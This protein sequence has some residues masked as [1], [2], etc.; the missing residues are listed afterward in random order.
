MTNELGQQIGAFLSAHHV[1]SL[2]TLGPSGPHA[3]NLLYACDGLALLWVSDADS[4]HSREIEADPRVEATVAPDYSDFAVIR[5]VQIAGSA[6]R[7]TEAVERMRHLA[8]LEARYAFLGQLAKAPSKLR[9]AYAR[10][11]VY[12]LQPTRIVLI[13]NSK[14][15]GH[16]ETLELSP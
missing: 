14:G 1:M 10:T 16:K 3:T 11:A 6:R 12:R 13:D 9:E 15:F 5:G 4:R 2:A 8:R 7:V